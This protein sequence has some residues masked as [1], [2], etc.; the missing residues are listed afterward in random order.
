MRRFSIRY[1]GS[2]ML[3]LSGTL[4]AQVPF[5]QGVNLTNWFQASSASQ[6][7]FTRFSKK[8]FQNIKSLGCD[9]IRLPINLHSMTNGAPDYVLDPLFLSFLDQAV[10][11]AEELDIHLIL[12]NHTFDPSA[13][14]DPN[15]GVVLVK[16]WSQMAAHYKD[17]SDHIYYEVLNEPHDISDVLWGGIQQTVIDAIRAQDSNHF[18]VVGGVNYNSYNS[19]NTIP[20]YSD[21]KLIYTFHFYDPF[22]FTHQ[23][24]SWINPSLVPLAGIPFP[25]RANGMPPGPNALKGTWV[26][27]LMN[28]YANDG[29]VAK[30]KQ[31]LDIAVNFGIQ[32]GVPVFCGEFGVYIPNSNNEDRVTWYTAV[33]SYLNQKNIPWTI[34]DYQGGFGLFNKDSNELFDYDL[35]APLLEALGFPVPVQKTYPTGPQATGFMIYDDFIGQGIFDNSTP[36]AGTLN[37]YSNEDPK[38]GE[39]SIH[40]TG[41]NQYD[42]IGFDFKPNLNLSLLPSNDF[43]LEFW[44]KG[45]T[46]GAKFDIRFMDTK[47][48]S[49]DRPWRMGR[50]IDNSLAAWD[51]NW[52]LIKIPLNV[53]EEKGAWDNGWFNPEGKFE[54]SKVDRFEI[55]PEHQ[56]LQNISFS[57]DDIRVLGDEI[58]IVTNIEDANE[59]HALRV[60]PNPMS[61]HVEIEYIPTSSNSSLIS[62]Y[63]LKGQTVKQFRPIASNSGSQKIIWNGTSNNGD[64]I[65]D[66]LYIVVMESAGKIKTAKLIVASE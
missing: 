19:L 10:D 61:A 29:T 32:R 45:D 27:S 54:W 3:F 51:G 11:W 5:Q 35:N 36:T 40:W 9:V 65:A 64:R 50:T 48:S 16:V 60:W 46:P 1:V 53:M 52:H 28:T 33:R 59:N 49:A 25:Y 4:S 57:L 24:A 13:P 55:V 8:D 47:T 34:W 37:F 22:I 7:Q 42:A 20:V 2:I 31:Q 62:I 17:R 15:I 14:T 30:I 6:I 26:E 12:D 23:G 21:T 63:D 43:V 58:T 66:G 56:A 18:I 39:N 44:V 38:I 41:V